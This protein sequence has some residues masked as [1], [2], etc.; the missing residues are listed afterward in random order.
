MNLTWETEGSIAEHIM[1][2]HC[3]PPLQ[4]EMLLWRLMLYWFII[5]MK[6]NCYIKNLQTSLKGQLAIAVKHIFVDFPFSRK[7]KNLDPNTNILTTNNILFP[8]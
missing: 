6:P 5:A 8:Y 1:L 2:L 3:T 4:K 7:I